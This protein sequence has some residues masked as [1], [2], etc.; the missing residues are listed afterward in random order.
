M[1]LDE[2]RKMNA[3]E[4]VDAYFESGGEIFPDGSISIPPPTGEKMRA[5][6]ALE[7]L[8][9]RPEGRNVLAGLGNS[10]LRGEVDCF[11]NPTT[12]TQ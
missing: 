9:K 8:L 7:Y 4:L 3:G 2:L 5:R 6:L 10:Y 12:A 1:P 11:G